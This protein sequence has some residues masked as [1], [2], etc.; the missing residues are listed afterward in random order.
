MISNLQTTRKELHELT[1]PL[2]IIVQQRNV[3]D[4]NLPLLRQD[5][6]HRH[7]RPRMSVRLHLRVLLPLRSLRKI[8]TA[9]IVGK[10]EGA[11]RLHA[12]VIDLPLRH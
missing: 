2:L 12:N 6:F 8:Q 5:P 4:L 7:S 3:R 1:L 11:L 10:E 9:F